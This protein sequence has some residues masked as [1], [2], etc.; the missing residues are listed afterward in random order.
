VDT[1]AIPELILAL[2]QVGRASEADRLFA[3]YRANASK[4]PRHGVGG[5][6]RNVSDANIAALSGRGDEALRLIDGISRRNPLSLNVIPTMS[7]LRNPVLAGVNADPRLAVA[8]ERLRAALNAERRKAGLPPIG[9]QAW[10][11]G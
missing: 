8:D 5:A 11:G 4:L 1:V 2:R 9:R 3:I 6:I 10:I 7:L